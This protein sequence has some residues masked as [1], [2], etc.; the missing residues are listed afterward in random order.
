K[1]KGKR[2]RKPFTFVSSPPRAS[3]LLG[4]QDLIQVH[5]QPRSLQL[6]GQL[7]L[8][9]LGRV[10]GNVVHS[11]FIVE[12]SSAAEVQHADAI[13][14]DLPAAKAHVEGREPGGKRLDPPYLLLCSDNI[15]IH[16]KTHN[17]IF[18]SSCSV[19]NYTGNLVRQRKPC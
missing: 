5:I 19:E 1:T 6:F 14:A 17:F 4:A 9:S 12:Q 2:P 7:N 16:L 15:W 13:R 8:P 10:D 11:I 3:E 18:D